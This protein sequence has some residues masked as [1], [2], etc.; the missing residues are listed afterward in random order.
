M[1]MTKIVSTLKWVKLLEVRKKI[2]KSQKKK[3]TTC[4]KSV[5][6]STSLRSVRAHLRNLMP[7][8]ASE[9]MD[10]DDGLSISDKG[11]LTDQD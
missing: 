10:M 4:V 6:K 7:N 3:H 9:R 11:I 5:K 1:L 2:E 8:E